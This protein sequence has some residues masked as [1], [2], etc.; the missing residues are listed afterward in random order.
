[1]YKFYYTS[2][3]YKWGGGLRLEVSFLIWDKVIIIY[4]SHFQ[5]EVVPRFI[6]TDISITICVT[7]QGRS[8]SCTCRS[9]A[10]GPGWTK[11]AT[12]VT[13]FVFQSTATTKSDTARG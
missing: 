6:D 10:G 3:N 13:A 12:A 9:F 5:S 11:T 7:R 4:T 8:A 2:D 1:M